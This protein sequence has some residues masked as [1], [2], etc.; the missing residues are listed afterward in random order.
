[1]ARALLI[2]EKPSL[3]R[4]VQAV[5]KTMN[6]PD[7]IDF[8]SFRGHTMTLFAPGDYTE[9]W[10]KWD[11]K[12]LPMIPQKFRYKVIEDG[13]GDY[14]NIF[15]DIKKTIEHGNYDYLINCCDPG[16]EG[17]LIFHSVYESLGC[18]LPV[19]RFWN[20]GMTE[21]AIMD[22]LNQMDDDLNTPRLKNMI[23]ASKL[24]ADF[25]WLIGMNFTRAFSIGANQRKA[26][27]LGRV[28]TPVLNM[29][30][31]REMELKDFKPKPY[32][33]I[34][35]DFGD[36]KG[37]YFDH[38]NENE[39][40]FFNKEKA[41]ALI[42]CLP[43]SGV[44]EKVEK[45]VEKKYA[46]SLHSLADL[47]REA[48]K[49]FSFTMSET[50]D[51]VQELYESK[52]L[53]YPRTDSAYI[54]QDE[55]KRFPQLLA[56]IKD[57]PEV[58]KYVQPLLNDNQTISK[59]AKNKKY[60][61]DKKVSDHYAIIPTGRSVDYTRLTKRQQ[62]IMGLV[63]KRFVAIFM[64]PSVVNKTSVITNLDG[65]K[66]KT[67]GNEVVDKG[68][69]A[70]YKTKFSE[71]S[72]PSLEV[73]QV[74]N[75]VQSELNE[76]STNPPSR[77]NDATILEAMINAGRFLED[78][79]LKE[80]LKSSEGIG[81]PATRGSIIEK[82]INLKMIERK[83]KTFYAT[84]YGI[85]I[86]QNLSNHLV[87]SPELT[88]QWEQKLKS[89]EA[90][91]LE[92]MVFWHEMIDYIKVATEEF[93]QMTYQI[94][95]VLA[96]YNSPDI[97]IIGDC[98]KCGQKVASGKNYFFCSEYKKTCDFISGK[99]ILGTKISEANMKKILQGK[100]SN[101]L[102]FKKTEAN[103]EK[104]SWKAALIYSADK[105]QITFQFEDSGPKVPTK[106][107]EIKCPICGK[108]LNETANYY[109]CPEHKKS[110]QFIIGKTYFGAPISALEV[111]QLLRGTMTEQKQVTFQDG[112]TAI[113]YLYLD[114]PTKKIKFKRA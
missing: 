108:N 114:S 20:N 83:K 90:C 59:T 25:D 70:I 107:L 113:G 45:K 30:A 62:Q 5:Y 56:A 77:Y 46:P 109:M 100:P 15:Q 75:L 86:I 41:D 57:V 17:Q 24:R 32:W 63:A 79:S 99:A 68:Y 8:K 40:K 87:A 101:V 38:E 39:T 47:Q 48:N 84:D 18:K 52:Y 16:R 19:R 3:M 72:L 80:V 31:Q 27:P 61:D 33:E 103:G 66:F 9:E 88:A 81:T 49:A 7:Q 26:L 29:I 36:Y 28:M 21:Q 1:M 76:K 6:F 65:R 53:S 78:S 35:A 11:L 22:A 2:A 34:E 82:L 95:G 43:R 89:I 92:P 69:T 74:V 111:E 105:Q 97:K 85:S 58:A 51:I 106:Q 14:L 10:E 98:P 94:Q 37:T 110:C 12:T 44:V 112:N 13:K 71:N 102:T 4:E 73:D 64:P 104:K 67:N 96:T 50:L 93:K 55:A 60:V 23:H 42:Q 91:E 54:T